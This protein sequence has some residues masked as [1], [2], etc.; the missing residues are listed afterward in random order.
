MVHFPL[1][2]S[3]S[4]ESKRAVQMYALFR[5]VKQSRSN[6]K[7]LHKCTLYLD[8]GQAIPF[9]SKRVAQMYALLD[10]GQAIPFVSKWLISAPERLLT[11]DVGDY[12]LSISCKSKKQRKTAS[13]SSRIIIMVNG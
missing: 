3:T 2:L 10:S 13:G 6:P 8:S 7:E 9:E 1:W 5:L 12:V 4:F 11:R